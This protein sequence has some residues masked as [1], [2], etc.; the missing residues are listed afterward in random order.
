[1]PEP[2]EIVRPLF[3]PR[4]GAVL[5]LQ[6]LRTLADG[7]SEAHGAAL[8]AR[9]PGAPGLVLTGFDIDGDPAP[10]GP[11]GTVRPDGLVPHV[12]V[13][14]GRALVRGRDGRLHLVGLDAPVGV[15]WPDASG[16][17][18]R[19]TLVLYASHTP[20]V[21]PNGLAVARERLV[22]QL[23]FLPPD[24]P[25]PESA[26]PLARAIGNAQD[27]TT[28][29]ARVLAP[30]HPGIRQLLKRLERLEETVWNTEPEG[31]VWDRQVFGRSWVRYQTVACAALQAATLEL[32]T[33]A[34]TTLDRA[35]LLA[36]LRRQLERSVERAATELL[37]VLAPSEATGPYRGVAGLDLTGAGGTGA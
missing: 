35:R 23:G 37:Q 14:P 33:H 26:L 4:E 10:A 36:T 28:D 19:A 27:W 32:G 7:T 24:R 25:E 20:E 17:R 2:T 13:R 21:G 1:M 3:S 11:P 5:D 18:V 6:S 15:P 31:A 8:L 12:T 16:P 9:W 34:L 30:D 22:V 29:I